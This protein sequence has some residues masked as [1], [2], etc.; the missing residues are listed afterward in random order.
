MAS[1]DPLRDVDAIEQGGAV[2]QHRDRPAQRVR[3]AREG[4]GAA[5]GGSPDVAVGWLTPV[6]ILVAASLLLGNLAALAQTNVRRL[7]AYSAI[8]H[9]GAMLLGV[10]AAEVTGQRGSPSAYGASG[11]A[12]AGDGRAVAFNRQA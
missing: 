2:I 12:N 3:D 5:A 11:R 8:A 6:A 10:I 1:H 7:L 4:L 9:A